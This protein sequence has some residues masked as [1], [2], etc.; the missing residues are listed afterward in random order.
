MKRPAV[1][2]W[3]A[4][5]LSAAL[6]VTAAPMPTPSYCAE[7]IKQST[8]GFERLT[9]FADRTLVWKTRRGDAENVKRKSLDA[10]EAK[11]YCEYFGR[12]EFWSLPEDQRSRIPGEFLTQSVLRIA[13]PDGTTKEVRFDELSALS[14]EA[15]ALRSSLEG[16]RRLFTDRIAPLSNFTARTL[17]P[18]TV[19]RRFDGVLFRVLI[20]DEGKGVVELE[21]VAEP[22]SFFRKIEELRFLFHPPTE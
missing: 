22:F 5:L 12:A 4:V 6:R 21:G 3:A 19:L 18:G 20:V 2:L 11:F 15:S 14:P 10:E 1:S 8:E 9:L 17:A 7:W 16:L 13:R